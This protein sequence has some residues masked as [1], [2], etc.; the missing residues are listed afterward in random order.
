[1]R[2][3]RATWRW[4]WASVALAAMITGGC[5]RQAREP[6]ASPP[7]AAR[8]QEPADEAAPMVEVPGSDESQAPEESGQAAEAPAAAGTIGE[9]IDS[10]T[11]PSSFRMTIE[12]GADT[13]AAA[14]QTD[15]RKMTRLRTD[16]HV[17]SDNYVF[18]TDFKSGE[19]IYC[20]LDTGQGTRQPVRSSDMTSPWEMYSRDAKV[21][22]S[23]EVE[24]VDCWL[25][26]MSGEAGGRMWV[27]KH[28]GLPRRAEAGDQITHFTITDVNAVPDSAFRVPDGI[29]IGDAPVGQ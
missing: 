1:M 26:D 23:E 21:V 14:I 28:D 18:I 25:I 8:A 12:E 27:G 11:M 16:N 20:N 6:A 19:K 29:A 22:G 17:Q 3:G 7:T 2:E 9:K 15:G 5:G 13:Y 4:I 10:F 24:G